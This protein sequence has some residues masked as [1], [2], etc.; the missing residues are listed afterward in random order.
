M[1]RRVV[2]LQRGVV[3]VQR[4]GGIEVAREA[5][6]RH[7]PLVPRQRNIHQLAARIGHQVGIFLVRLPRVPGL[8][9]QRRQVLRGGLRRRP[10]G[11]IGVVVVEHA[12]VRSAL[13]PEVVRLRRMNVRIV[14]ARR[15]QHVVIRHGIRHMLADIHHTAVNVGGRCPVDQA[16]DERRAGIL[17]N[18][19]NPAGGPGIVVGLGPVVIL[20]RDDEHMFHFARTILSTRRGSGQVHAEHKPGAGANKLHGGGHRCLQRGKYGR[21]GKVARSLRADTNSRRQP[22]ADVDS[23]AMFT[24][25]DHRVKTSLRIP[26]G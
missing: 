19:L 24:N 2:I 26:A 7:R 16:V 15:G 12:V 21:S 25:D 5:R 23:P 22:P 6:K 20:Q 1:F 9:Q 10:A 3:L 14:A 11:R 8:L 4:A 17:V 13:G 18:L